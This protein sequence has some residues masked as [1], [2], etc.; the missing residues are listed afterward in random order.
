MLLTIICSFKSG[1]NTVMADND[2]CLSVMAELVRLVF[3]DM[4]KE[5]AMEYVS[6][7]MTSSGSDSYKTYSN[8]AKRSIEKTIGECD[9][10]FHFLFDNNE[11]IGKRPLR[12]MNIDVN[13]IELPQELAHLAQQMPDGREILY[14]LKDE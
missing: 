14:L 2:K 13:N 9:D 5:D 11:T 12:S 4:P 3:E 10:A 7:Y 1:Y 8:S 6:K